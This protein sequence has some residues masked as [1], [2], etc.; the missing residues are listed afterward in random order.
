MNLFRKQNKL[1]LYLVN[2][3]TTNFIR[4]EVNK[5]LEGNYDE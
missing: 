3:P 5:K 2:L 1:R 4:K